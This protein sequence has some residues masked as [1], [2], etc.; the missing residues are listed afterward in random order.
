[1]PSRRAYIES[2]KRH[3][4]QS[5]L[6]A[7]NAD[8]IDKGEAGITFRKMNIDT[9]TSILRKCRYFDGLLEFRKIRNDQTADA[10]PDKER[11]IISA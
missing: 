8:A 11:R 7:F 10:N 3:M 9:D 4:S 2:V 5:R 1:M 6:S